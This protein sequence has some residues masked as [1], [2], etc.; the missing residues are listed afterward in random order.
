[1]GVGIDSIFHQDREHIKTGRVRS[2]EFSF[3]NFIGGESRL[4]QHKP[5]ECYLNLSKSTI[6]LGI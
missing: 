4:G 3:R 1:M 6:V 2:G 5:R